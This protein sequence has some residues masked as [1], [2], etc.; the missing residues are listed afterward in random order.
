MMAEIPLDGASASLPGGEFMGPQ[1]RTRFTA[2]EIRVNPSRNSAARPSIPGRFS[3]EGNSTVRAPNRLLKASTPESPPLPVR[4]KTPKPRAMAGDYVAV[5]IKG[6]IAGPNLTV[7]LRQPQR[8]RGLAGKR[9]ANVLEQRTGI[10]DG[11]A[12]SP[13]LQR[14]LVQGVIPFPIRRSF[15]L[16]HGDAVAVGHAHPPPLAFLPIPHGIRGIQLF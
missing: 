11:G 6:Q 9:V 13:P 2:A 7:V 4:S 14:K 1:C 16:A 12:F 5:V 15:G 10:R 3:Q 8:H